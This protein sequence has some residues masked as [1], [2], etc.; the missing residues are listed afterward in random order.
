MGRLLGREE[1]RWERE[2]GWAEVWAGADWSGGLPGERKWAVGK[3]EMGCGFGVVG[4]GFGFLPFS[5]PFSFQKQFE[6][7]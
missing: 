2:S 3:G 7:K 4:L 5:I 1:G 6:F